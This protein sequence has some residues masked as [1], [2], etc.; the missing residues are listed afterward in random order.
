[1]LIIAFVLIFV[2]RVPSAVV[3]GRLCGQYHSAFVSVRL[4]FM[5]VHGI[6]GFSLRFGPLGHV[7]AGTETVIGV[8]VR[9][10]FTHSP[11]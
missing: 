2:A 4:L 11:W 8:R 1:M 5:E 6:S 3:R 7:L 9:P 10:I